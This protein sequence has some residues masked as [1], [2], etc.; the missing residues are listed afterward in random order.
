MPTDEPAAQ[1]RDGG[2]TNGAATTATTRPAA[3]VATPAG[4]AQP[5]APVAPLW[6]DDPDA[7]E[8]KERDGIKDRLRRLTRRPD[9]HDDSGS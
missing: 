8:G 1:A 5:A 3:A 2:P 4:S 6:V 7:P 9:A